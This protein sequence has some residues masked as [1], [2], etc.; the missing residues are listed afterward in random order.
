[1]QGKT[2]LT[3]GVSSALLIMLPQSFTE[4]AVGTAAAAV[5]SVICDIDQGKSVSHKYAN[6]VIQYITLAIIIVNVLDFTG[7]GDFINLWKWILQQNVLASKI[8]VF[9]F[10]LII[11]IFGMNQPHRGF[12]HSVMS[13]M[14]TGECVKFL[15]PMT[16]RYYCIAFISHI[17]LD[18]FNKKGIQ[19][20]C[21]YP[22]KWCMKICSSKGKADKVIGN[23]G[24]VTMLII[25]V[26]MVINLWINMQST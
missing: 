21:P 14:A 10:L 2:H 9:V 17:V 24:M 23:I 3:V 18:L 1:M 5:G 15:L 7:N 20:L 13:L 4:L 6:Y 26:A 12:M 11:C 8:A 16:Y 25:V 22:K 19:I